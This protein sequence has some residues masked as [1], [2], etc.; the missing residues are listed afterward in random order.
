MDEVA[1]RCQ[2]RIGRG[3]L[4]GGGGGSVVGSV[5][6]AAI[7]NSKSPNS[8]RAAWLSGAGI[9]FQMG[10]LIGGFTGGR[11]N[12]KFRIHGDAT[13]FKN[14]TETFLHFMQHP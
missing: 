2:D 10:G 6:V 1:F 11:L 7:S 8:K 5:L 14:A 9:G 4:I 3:I 12:K 13:L